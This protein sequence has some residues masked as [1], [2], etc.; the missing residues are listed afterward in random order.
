MSEAR[1]VPERNPHSNHR[2]PFAIMS[3]SRQPDT[4]TAIMLRQPNPQPTTT[5]PP[6]GLPQ[7]MKSPGAMPLKSRKSRI[8]WDWS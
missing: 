3:P 5:L 2:N 4:G 8:R 1:F 6:S 7:R